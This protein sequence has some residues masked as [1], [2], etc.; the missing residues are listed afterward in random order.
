M[1]ELEGSL[2]AIRPRQSSAVAK[3]T[4]ELNATL[5]QMIVDHWE[6]GHYVGDYSSFMREYRQHAEAISDAQGALDGAGS[7]SDTAKEN[8]A[9]PFP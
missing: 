9:H 3:T 6:G 5:L 2:D 1:A 4:G 8:S 7:S